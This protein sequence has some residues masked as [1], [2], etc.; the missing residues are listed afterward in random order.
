[1]IVTHIWN[2]QAGAESESWREW[3]PLKD[4]HHWQYEFKEKIE[5]NP[6]RL[7]EIEARL[8]L[9]R[10]LKRKY[11]KTIP[12]ILAF[13]TQAETIK[14]GYGRILCSIPRELTLPV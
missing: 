8:E 7:E 2:I 5:E 1:M 12:D 13:R 11:G 4:D 14:C 6:V 3:G 10:N 9:I